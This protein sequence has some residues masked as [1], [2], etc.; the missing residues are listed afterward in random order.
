MPGCSSGVWDER[1]NFLSVHEYLLL[2]HCKYCERNSALYLLQPVLYKKCHVFNVL[3]LFVLCCSWKI[4][5]EWTRDDDVPSISLPAI[6]T[7]WLVTWT[8]DQFSFCSCF[9][10][11]A[12]VRGYWIFFFKSKLLLHRCR[13]CHFVL[14]CRKVASSVIVSL[15]VQDFTL[16]LW[17]LFPFL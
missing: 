15:T 13:W 10:F 14:T 6:Q 1:Y 7:V 5:Q 12:S 8:E 4:S 2:V 17:L 9:L 16:L 3:L 11:T